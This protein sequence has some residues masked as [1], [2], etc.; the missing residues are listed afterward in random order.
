MPHC[1]NSIAVGEAFSKA[2]NPKPLG[3]EAVESLREYP[4]RIFSYFFLVTL[5]VWVVG[6]KLVN[7]R[8]NR[9][10]EASWDKLLRPDGAMFV[11]MTVDMHMNGECYL[12]AG[13]VDEFKVDKNGDL[14]RV[15]LGWAARRPLKLP[16]GPDL[17]ADDDEELPG[18]WVEIP[19]EA[20]VL[21]LAQSQTMNLDYFYAMPDEDTEGDEVEG[22]VL[23]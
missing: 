14:E 6:R 21:K 5:L 16:E 15:V 13:R 4:V 8:F 11:W 18:W 22:E 3:K 23:G 1:G 19:G 2:G 10:G 9:R 12:F 20:I 7:K 17:P